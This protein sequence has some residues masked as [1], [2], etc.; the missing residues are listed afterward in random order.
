MTQKI[1]YDLVL[2]LNL[3]NF[4][5]KDDEDLCNGPFRGDLICIQV[6]NEIQ[7]DLLLVSL[8]FST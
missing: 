7:S 4:V 2:C 1:T 5:Q 3:C 8:K 6:K